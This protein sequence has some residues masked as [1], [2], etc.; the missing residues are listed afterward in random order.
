MVFFYFLTWILT[1]LQPGRPENRQEINCREGEFGTKK[2]DE[3][4]EEEEAEDAKNF[5]KESEKKSE[6]RKGERG[7][8]GITV[9]NKATS[10]LC[11]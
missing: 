5:G 11:S 4:E 2:E 6:E 9:N 1:S 10:L 7:W 3:E 8:M